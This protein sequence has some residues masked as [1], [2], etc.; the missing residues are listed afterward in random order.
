MEQIDPKYFEDVVRGIK[1]GTIFENFACD[2]LCQVI[3]KEFYPAGG[4]HDQGI[5]GIRYFKNAESPESPEYKVIYQISIDEAASKV[6]DTLD[7]LQKNGISFSELY[8]VTNDI[9]KKP[10][11]LCTKVYR[12]YHIFLHIYDLN[13]FRGNVNTSPGTMS[14]FSAF[15]DRYCH[16]FTSIG[17]T[18]IIE[19][20]DGD[21]RI[22]IF[23]RQQLERAG[24]VDNL[25][26]IVLDS[27][28]IYALEGTDPDK[29]KFMSK[30]DILEKITTIAPV[31]FNEETFEDRLSV[32]STK[33]RRINHHR[34]QNQYCLPYETRQEIQKLNIHDESVVT[35]FEK[36]IC[37]RILEENI[38]RGFSEKDITTDVICVVNEIFK[39]SGFEFSDF[40]LSPG[41][42]KNIVQDLPKTIEQIV[43]KKQITL[44]KERKKELCDSILTILRAVIYSPNDAEREYLSSLSKTY[45]TLFMLRADPKIANYLRTMARGLEIF[46]CSSILIPA[47]SEIM[48]PEKDRRLWNM[49]KIA[50]DAGVRFLVNSSIVD[51]IVQHIENKIREYKNYYDG[52]EEI[53][54][55]PQMISE[56]D[57][58]LIRGFFYH[59][60]SN[61]SLTFEDYIDNFVNPNANKSDKKYELKNF[62]KDEFGI[63]AVR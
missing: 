14:V 22:L 45:M 54:S 38:G 60:L 51:E 20:F 59:R 7:K 30:E 21:P 43:L 48:A 13:W 15:V 42:T 33:P 52:C 8:F 18:R 32:L 50:R 19:D 26:N 11:E 36:S 34:S 12:K 35:R 2:C 9:V 23:L 56:V 62:F 17:K 10:D 3:G 6:Y 29:D 37:N 25:Q 27:M 39:R 4:I 44:T 24:D 5:D 28:I 47:L 49:L 58:I 41:K 31:R 16:E 61:S 1:Q 63:T 53:Y 46:V 57:S 55:D 40:I